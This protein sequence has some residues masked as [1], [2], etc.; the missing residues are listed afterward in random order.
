MVM[1]IVYALVG[2]YESAI[3][4]LAFLLSIPAWCTPIQLRTDPIF[5]PLQD[6]PRFKQLL[7][8]YER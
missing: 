4:E 7:K 1:A 2:E 6:I 3:D 5:A 8:Q